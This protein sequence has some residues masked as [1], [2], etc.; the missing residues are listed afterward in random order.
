MK[1][2]DS[3]APACLGGRRLLVKFAFQKRIPHDTRRSEAALREETLSSAMNM[4]PFIV[5]SHDVPENH[6]DQAR[7]PDSD[8]LGGGNSGQFSKTST[9]RESPD[10]ASSQFTHPMNSNEKRTAKKGSVSSSRSGHSKKRSIQ[11]TQLGSSAT[12]LSL[13]N[14]AERNN[15]TKH[16]A[17][18]TKNETANAGCL[19]NR[20]AA[21]DAH[22]IQTIP[23]LN[24]EQFPPLAVSYPTNLSKP[25]AVQLSFDVETYRESQVKPSGKEA[26]TNENEPAASEFDKLDREEPQ[27]K[28]MKKEAME[29]RNKPPAIKF[30]ELCREEPQ[31]KPIEEEARKKENESP[32]TISDKFDRKQ[33]SSSSGMIRAEKASMAQRVSET[34]LTEPIFR[35]H[36]ELSVCDSNEARVSVNQIAVMEPFPTRK[37]P[38]NTEIGWSQPVIELG[39]SDTCR[40]EASAAYGKTHV[41]KTRNVLSHTVALPMNPPSASQV[42]AKTQGKVP[43]NDS[44]FVS[45]SPQKS[46]VHDST[47]SLDNPSMVVTRIQSGKDELFVTPTKMSMASTVKASPVILSTAS[48]QISSAVSMKAPKL[49]ESHR[50]EVPL[51][52]SSLPPSSTPILT[53][54]K[55][56]KV[57][58]PVEVD[59]KDLSGEIV[60]CPTEDSTDLNPIRNFEQKKADRH[61]EKSNISESEGDIE[62]NK[63]NLDESHE[64]MAN[65]Q[66]AAPPSTIP[67]EVSHS[68]E[69]EDTA[70]HSATSAAMPPKK[71][72]RK[73]AGRKQK[74]KSKAGQPSCDQ[75]GVDSGPEK[76]QSMKNLPEPETPYLVDNQFILPQVTTN[77]SSPA[78]NKE[79]PHH[80][81]TATARYQALRDQERRTAA[82]RLKAI[83]DQETD[84]FDSCD[85]I[86]DYVRLK[87]RTYEP[88]A[89]YLQDKTTFSSI[90]SSEPVTREIPSEDIGPLARSA[91]SPKPSD[92][93]QP[94]A[95]IDQGSPKLRAWGHIDESGALLMLDSHKS[96]FESA[97]N[98]SESNRE[99]GKA[100]TNSSLSSDVDIEILG[101][102]DD[103]DHLPDCNLKGADNTG[104]EIILKGVDGYR[105]FP[106]KLLKEEVT[107]ASDLPF[108]QRYSNLDSSPRAK[109]AMALLTSSFSPPSPL[110]LLATVGGNSSEEVAFDHQKAEVAAL[111]PKQATPDKIDLSVSTN[112]SSAA[113]TVVH[114]QYL[115]SM[116]SMHGDLLLDLATK[117]PI[118]STPKGKQRKG[119]RRGSS[120]RS[121]SSSSASST[122]ASATRSSF[123]S[124]NHL[125]E[126][127][128]AIS[129]C[130]AS[131]CVTKSEITRSQA[132]S[133]PP[134]T[135]THRPHLSYGAAALSPTKGSA[136]VTS[137]EVIQL[138]SPVVR[139]RAA[140][141][142]ESDHECKTVS[143]AS[144]EDQAFVSL[145]DRLESSPSVKSQNEKKK[146]SSKGD[147]WRVPSGEMVWGIASDDGSGSGAHKSP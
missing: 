31:V 131:Q 30:D 27:V 53:H 15:K 99:K 80:A 36:P 2:L 22:V 18:S 26:C 93:A 32:A 79:N 10:K 78:T 49:L 65:L 29:E 106:E 117:T 104:S 77:K 66:K 17:K 123:D 132:S 61:V 48:G 1:A 133:S 57:F 112:V 147:P 42:V 9:V 96:Q 143:G 107:Q 89:V 145:E 62:E 98:E 74:S 125:S 24:P 33:E 56:Q 139:G 72:K 109:S 127:F 25:S 12:E 91:G 43:E 130:S 137:R 52:T 135:P 84:Q 47:P 35:A 28:P 118:P 111:L 3:T 128:S 8:A 46:V 126:A 120:S 68:K 92:I 11:K 83:R 71:V 100:R 142:H 5:S 87:E 76:P 41:A 90:Y 63:C 58:T 101:T 114:D 14:K 122:A 45:I 105:S 54:K 50:P 21:T 16:E 97:L 138:G 4:R 20:G 102:P 94:L 144:F 13:N 6:I 82:V 140:S 141:F 75:T 70:Q 134:G 39:S 86:D 124:S 88:F 146:S 40:L 34:A 7:K 119:H 103:S 121:V 110:P 73:S 38:T 64:E 69:Q 51:R 81:R 19:G 23:G 129:V 67:G 108:R 37:P 115:D 116:S 113:S 44:S 95:W 85:N 136:P 55:K 59:I 60:D